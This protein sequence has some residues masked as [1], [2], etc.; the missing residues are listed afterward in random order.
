MTQN[1]SDNQFKKNPFAVLVFFTLLGVGLGLFVS[2][3]YHSFIL[4]FGTLAVFCVIGL[5]IYSYQNKG[6]I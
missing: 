2:E 6:R 5:I 3:A 1:R 4:G